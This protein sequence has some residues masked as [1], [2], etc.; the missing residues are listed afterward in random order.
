MEDGEVLAA[1]SK[2]S[3]AA[4][5]SCRSCSKKSGGVIARIRWQPGAPQVRTRPRLARENPCESCSRRFG[6]AFGLERLGHHSAVGFF[7][8]NFDFAFGFLELLLTLRRECNTLFEKVHGLVERK[9]WALELADHLFQAR[10]GTF[11]IGF[12]GRVGFFLSRCIHALFSLGKSSSA[13][14][15]PPGNV[16]GSPAE[17]AQAKFLRHAKQP[18]VYGRARR[19]NKR[20]RDRRWPVCTPKAG[21]AGLPGAASR[22]EGQGVP[23]GGGFGGVGER[24]DDGAAVVPVV[25]LI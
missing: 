17:P 12:L 15:R 14:S 6:L 22:F 1:G 11:E 18:T 4:S 24:C 7:E 9:L 5:T 13:G 10:Q 19:G 23:A 2:R 20:R 25:E 3:R 16:G 8:K 21:G